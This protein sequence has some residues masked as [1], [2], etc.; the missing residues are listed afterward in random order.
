[1][2]RVNAALDDAI[3]VKRRI[4]EEL[5]PTLLDNL[6]I[7]AAL[8][9]QCEQFTKRTGCRCEPQLAEHDL[10]LSPELSIAIYR[11]VQEALTNV[12]KYAK[13]NSVQVQLDR[14]GPRW[15]LRV[16]DDGV[17]LDI[18]K[19]HHPTS[20]GLISIR[21]RVRALGGELRISGGPGMG[22]TIDAWFPYVSA[23]E[24][25]GTIRE[26]RDEPE[27]R[28]PARRHAP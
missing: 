12:T 25:T 28:A 18:A 23:T 15:H 9:W 16:H 1:M 27:A 11:I 5:R 24:W 21:E 6:G 17:G 7:G 13:A 3:T 2:Q 4:I 20:H 14:D 22:T 26:A 8:R 10:Q 19:Q